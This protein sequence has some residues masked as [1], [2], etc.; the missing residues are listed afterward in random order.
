MSKRIYIISAVISILLMGCAA[1]KVQKAYYSQP[2]IQKASNS[3][4]DVQIE[5][6][7]LDNPFYVAFMLTLRNKTTD[8]LAINWDRIPDPQDR[9][10]T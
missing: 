8:A 7:K 3:A 9:G 1:Q 5:P 6:E 2:E 4:F 10:R